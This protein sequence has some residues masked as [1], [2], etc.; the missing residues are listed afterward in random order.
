VAEIKGKWPWPQNI[1]TLGTFPEEVKAL[2]KL[3]VNP[4]AS[5]VPAAEPERFL[6]PRR[7]SDHVRM[8]GPPEEGPLK[9][10]A[11][12]LAL[13]FVLFRRVLSRRKKVSWGVFEDAVEAQD[14]DDGLPDAR[15]DQMRSMLKRE[16]AMLDILHRYHSM[17][18]MV[19][20]RLIGESKG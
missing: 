2:R 18:E 8:G 17:A 1:G 19:Y 9:D 12:P 15:R 13:H 16:Q 20:N 5:P 11:T 4:D 14:L 7:S 10:P 3:E 6:W